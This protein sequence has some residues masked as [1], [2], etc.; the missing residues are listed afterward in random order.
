M[1]AGRVASSVVQ[2][3]VKYVSPVPVAAA[4]G[5]VAKVYGQI[6]DEMRLVIPP[7]LLHSPAPDVLAA[8]WMLT[9]EPLLPTGDVDRATKEAVAAAVSVATIC[10]Y[11]VDMHSVSMYD[12]STEHDAEAVCADRVDEMADPWLRDVTAW[13]RAA[14][15][16]DGSIP[17]P[18]S[19][20]AAARAELIGMV[21]SMHYLTRMVNVFLS[22]FLLPP[23]LGPRSRR[24]LKHGISRM[25]RPTLR[26]SR[27][28]GRSLSLLS[29]A[30]LPPSAAWAAGSPAIAAA[31]ASSYA[32]FE[33]AGARALSPAVCEI[34]VDRLERWR[35]EETG[36][37]TAWCEELIA[38]LAPADRAAGRLTLLTAL[39][40][41]KIDE[42]VV[43]EFRRYHPADATLVDATAWA[44]F[45]A[46]RL[47]GARQGAVTGGADTASVE[48]RPT[49]TAY[50][51]GTDA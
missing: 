5:L 17:M 44:S 41:Y 7:A 31:I 1:I 36:L 37:S 14:H 6:A 38:D 46:A 32:A 3:Q 49:V 22:N 51:D 33:A 25:M 8:Y 26:A 2:R 45:A 9:R 43:G 28:P 42:E 10:P 40:S 39:A 11:C 13:A 48:T 16:C 50:H 12:L 19:L 27:E 21:V 15:E 35:G 18:D 30:P 29:P 47:I 24:R 4:T 34:T 23:G 20:T